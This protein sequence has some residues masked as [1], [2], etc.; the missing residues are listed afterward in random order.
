VA[1]RFSGR[2]SVHLIVG[3]GE[4]EREM[5]ERIAWAHDRGLGIGLFAFTP[6]RGTALAER[7]PPSLAVYRR[8]QAARWLI[9]RGGARLE[10]FRFD[11]GGALVGICLPDAS[12]LASLLAG[13]EAFRTSGCPD[14]N[15]PFYNERP[16]GPQYNYARPLTSVE[17]RR[18]LEEMGLALQ[19]TSTGSTCA[20]AS[21]S[22]TPAGSHSGG[23]RPPQ[24]TECGAAETSVSKRKWLS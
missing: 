24:R 17:A 21:G 2:A 14:C 9:V 22:V 15:R 3:L 11:E 6:V 18:A 19:G 8:M 5:V 13:G 20:A 1:R 7:A 23:R 12:D 4:S 10:A 16:G